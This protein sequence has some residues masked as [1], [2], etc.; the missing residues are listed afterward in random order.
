MNKNHLLNIQPT[1]NKSV[2][3][4]N[5]AGANILIYQNNKEIGYWES[6]YRDIENKTAFS[7][8]TICRLYSMSKPIT[9]V[10]IMTLLEEGKI[11]L[12]DE[13]K[14]YLPFFDKLTVC[15][16]GKIEKCSRPLIIQDLLNMTSGYSYGGDNNESEKQISKLLYCD[17]DSSAAKE[18]NITTMDF[19]KRMSEIP[20]S[21][22]PGT[23]YTYGL[24]ADI[25]GAIIE[26]VT[27][28]KF[29]SYLKMK[30]FEPLEMKDTGFYVP[31]QN[32]N[33]LSKVYQKTKEGNLSLYESCHLGIQN[34]MKLNPCFESGGAGLVSTLDDYM[35]FT[36]MLT[37][38]G[39]LNG[40][41]I[42]QAKTVEFMR[43]SSLR[44]NLQHC[45][46]N[47]MEH[48]SGY[49]YCNLLRVCT[50]PSKARAITEKGEFGWDGW[51][52]PYMSVDIQN[53]LSIVYLMQLVDSGTT[54]VTRKLKNIIYTSL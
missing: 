13:V 25:L 26:N 4:K 39:E 30:I 22:E 10:A 54:N 15:K 49:T 45:F 7:R 32:Q 1:L 8:D 27:G 52:G 18:N 44:D 14:E 33:R 48:L 46:D 9:S 38:K 42:L 41:R 40:R 3:N 5:I 2:A 51:L 19:A 31:E 43:N 29:S 23:D 28:M 20:L 47:R 6:G 16:N 36:R 12:Y 11:E 34:S 37:N 50:E 35:K 17:L 24:S 21:F 53:D